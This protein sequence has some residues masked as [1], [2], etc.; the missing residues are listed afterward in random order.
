M[1][2]KPTREVDERY[3]EWISRRPCCITGKFDYDPD[4]GERRTDPH[5]IN[6]RGHGGI[7]TKSTDRRCIPL[8][9]ELHVEAHVLGRD[10]FAA[11]YSLDYD[12]LIEAYNKVYEK[13][14]RR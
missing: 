14:E 3:R 2:P 7:A 4:T 8:L 9:H 12:V 6:P 5:H 11:K 10:S 13:H 1:L